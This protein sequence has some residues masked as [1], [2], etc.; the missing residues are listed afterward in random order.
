MK[1]VF[2]FAVRIVL[3]CTVL[4]GLFPFANA[5]EDKFGRRVKQLLLVITATQFHFI[6]YMSRPLPNT[7]ALS[8]G[9]FRPN[10]K[11]VWVYCTPAITS[12]QHEI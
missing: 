4:S 7:F 9:E 3:G 2:S 5:I 12:A 11:K 8:L 6:F 1:F 10:L